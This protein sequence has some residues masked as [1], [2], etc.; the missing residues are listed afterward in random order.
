[1]KIKAFK[2]ELLKEGMMG[3]EWDGREREVMRGEMGKFTAESFWL[4]WDEN[5]TFLSWDG[6]FLV[7]SVIEVNRLWIKDSDELFLVND[8]GELHEVRLSLRGREGERGGS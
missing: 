8:A 2:N 7:S 6:F 3:V 1:M 5:E 4:C